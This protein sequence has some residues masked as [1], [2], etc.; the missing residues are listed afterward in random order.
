MTLKVGDQEYTQTL[1][2][3]KD[4]RSKGTLADIKATVDLQVALRK[5]LNTVSDMISQIEWMRK[6]CY[7]LK[8]VLGEGGGTRDT[9]SAIEVFDKKLRSI[10]D[11]LFQHTI[12]EGD[13]KSFRYPHKLYSKLSVL[14]GNIGENIDFAPTAQQLEVHA[15]LH[16][17]LAEQ[18]AH[19]EALLKTDLPTFNTML[20]RQDLGGVIVP[21]IKDAIPQAT[22]RF[23]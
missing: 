14:A 15:V 2:V 4:P 7:D 8:D 10:E 5:D 19:F 22:F 6:Q 18:K 11:E 13:T 9:I 12:A 20:E 17:R 21:Q 23:R 3:L 1:E 16:E